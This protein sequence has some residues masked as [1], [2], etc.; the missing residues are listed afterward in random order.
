MWSICGSQLEV[1]LAKRERAQGVPVQTGLDEIDEM[2]IMLRSRV[3]HCILRPQAPSAAALHCIVLRFIARH[4][5]ALHFTALHCTALHFTALHC[6]ALYCTAPCIA[7]G[8]YNPP[9]PSDS[10]RV[11][12]R[13]GMAES[14]ISAVG[15]LQA[16]SES[17]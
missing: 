8:H 14:R 5:L 9:P 12:V 2:G 6:P 10:K 1:I 16:A 3:H 11:G 17:H 7:A 13:I 15:H 4:C